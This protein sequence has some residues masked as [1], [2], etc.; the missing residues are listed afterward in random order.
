MPPTPFRSHCSHLRNALPAAAFLLL[1]HA[2]MAQT[3]LP[4]V[5]HWD[6]LKTVKKSEG[7]MV[8]GREWGE[9]KFWDRQGRPTE[10]ADFKSGERDGHVV[11]F[12]DN[13]QVQHDGWIRKGKQDSLM[14]SYYRNG[15]LMEEGSYAKGAKQG[16]CNYRKMLAELCDKGDCL[17]LDAWDRDSTRTLVKGEGFIRTY[18]PSGDTATTS[19]YHLG[20]LSGEQREYWPA[21]NLKAKGNWVGGVKD[22]PWAYWTSANAPETMETWDKG[23]LHGSFTS[24]FPSG[25]VKVSGFFAHGAKDSTWT[26]YTASGARDML[27]NF[28]AGQQDG[29]WK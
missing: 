27:G 2:A 1:A 15:Q 13:G 25:Q 17:S 14:R 24:Y 16:P 5:D 18:Y 19:R 4:Y 3:V 6:S 28:K 22:G 10:V 12:Y 9:W 11:I 20:V 21:G 29:L 8:N 7:L 23:K 26:W